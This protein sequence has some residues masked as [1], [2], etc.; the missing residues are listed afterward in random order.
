MNFKKKKVALL[1]PITSKDRDWKTLYQSYF[2]NLTFKSFCEIK[3]NE[4]DYTFYVGIDK[5]DKLFDQESILN[6]MNDILNHQNIKFDF[7]IFNGIQKGHLTAMWNILYE[8]AIKYENDF[9][10]QCGDDIIF[11]TKGWISES[12]EYLERNNGIGIVGPKNVTWSNF[13]LTQAMISRKHFE[14]FGYL[15]PEEIKN[16]Y[17]DNWIS[18]IYY[19]NYFMILDKHW[20]PNG[21][22][23]ERYE[24]NYNQ[25]IYK[26]LLQPS[27]EKIKQFIN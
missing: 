15:F 18:E 12:I 23:N 27:K 6:E 24:V 21:G 25:E 9:F 26:R 19:P 1:M 16:W 7:T 4:Y 3:E 11:K 14:I 17:C 22:G 5:D 8:K 2:I 13:I 10:Y 20:A